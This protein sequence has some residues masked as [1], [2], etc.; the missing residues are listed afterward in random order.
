MVVA[1]S[2]PTYVSAC[3]LP[4]P[5]QDLK[6]CTKKFSLWSTP[7]IL[8][9]QLK[10]F[11][12]TNVRSY[13]NYGTMATT[14]KITTPVDFPDV[15]D[16]SP[17]ALTHPCFLMVVVPR[18]AAATLTRCWSPPLFFVARMRVGGQIHPGRAARGRGRG[19]RNTPL[20]P[21]RRHQSEWWQVAFPAR[22]TD[23]QTGRQMDR[24]IGGGHA[25][26]RT[27]TRTREKDI[28]TRA[29]R[30]L[31]LP[32]CQ[33][34]RRSSGLAGGHYY[35]YARTLSKVRTAEWYQYNDSY[36]SKMSADAVR[37]PNAYVLFYQRRAWNGGHQGPPIVPTPADDG[38]GGAV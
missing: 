17:C 2:F 1:S 16:L 8:V 37:T 13:S 35:T 12:T 14:E 33:T 5:M 26:T 10:R 15:L 34:C 38:G 18:D 21:L 29:Q 27:R 19:R 11:S 31:T 28:S 25:R 9:I 4:M 30:P 6:R 32:C 36:V 22:Q 24:W 3:C 23:S 20:R 7:N